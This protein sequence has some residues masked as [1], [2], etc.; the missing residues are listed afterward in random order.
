MNQ[1]RKFIGHVV[2]GGPVT[3][4]EGIKAGIIKDKPAVPPEEPKKETEC[5][6]DKCI[7][8][9]GKK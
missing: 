1:K 4:Q 8:R 9:E 7:F 3:V 2:S 5:F 6:N